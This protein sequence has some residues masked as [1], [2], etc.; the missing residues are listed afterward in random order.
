M[1]EKSQIQLSEEQKIAKKTKLYRTISRVLIVLSVIIIGVFIYYA[2]GTKQNITQQ[3]AID[4]QELRSKLK[5]IISLENQYYKQNNKYVSF[6]FLQL[7]PDLQN[8]DPSVDGNFKYK[9]DSSTGT[10]TGIEKNESS[11]VNGDKDGNDGL[12]LTVKWEPGVVEGSL[13]RNF[14]WPDDDK[15]EFTQKSATPA[16]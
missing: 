13:G 1:L 9:F 5:Q 16:K 10:V 6:D 2:W 11:D 4:T 12:T 7:C 15:V 3:T 14:F 8:Y